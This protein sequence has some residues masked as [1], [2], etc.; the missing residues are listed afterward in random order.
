MEFI[1]LFLAEERATQALSSSLP[2]REHTLQLVQAAT[3]LLE[4]VAC[5]L[6]EECT[7]Q[8]ICAFLDAKTTMQL[9][10]DNTMKPAF[11]LRSER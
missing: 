5:L 9:F 11:Y 2:V 8:V 10:F 3:Y 6:A 1:S 7:M 4:L